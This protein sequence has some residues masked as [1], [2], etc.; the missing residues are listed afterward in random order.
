MIKTVKEKAARIGRQ[1]IRCVITVRVS[2]LVF[3]NDGVLE[4]GSILTLCFEKSGR[5]ATSNQILFD[6]SFDD[7]NP[8]VS[9]KHLKYTT[10]QVD[11]KLELAVSLYK[12]SD[13]NEYQAKRGKITIRQLQRNTTLGVDA[14]KVIGSHILLLHEAV[15]RLSSTPSSCIEDTLSMD[16]LPGSS[17]QVNISMKITHKKRGSFQLRKSIATLSKGAL[18][19]WGNN[20]HTGR[21]DTAGLGDED[22]TGSN[23]SD[24]SDSSVFST[25]GATFYYEDLEE[26]GGGREI[27]VTTLGGTASPQRLRQ[28]Q[29]AQEQ[30]EISDY[31]AVYSD[32]N[33][34]SRLQG[35]LPSRR[36]SGLHVMEVAMN[37]A[38]NEHILPLPKPA[39]KRPSLPN[40]TSAQLPSTQ[41]GTASSESLLVH[42][43]DPEGE[44][45]H[46]GTSSTEHLLEASIPPSLTIPVAHTTHNA[47][48]TATV[49]LVEAPANENSSSKSPSARHLCRTPTAAVA[50][51]GQRHRESIGSRA[52]IG[53]DWSP[54]LAG[55]LDHVSGG[56]SERLAL[57]AGKGGSRSSLSSP[58]S[59]ASMFISYY[60]YYIYI[61]I[62]DRI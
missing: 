42:S 4:P 28:H 11:E 22:E 39:P 10:I 21:K 53:N 19:G 16:G 15:E 8:I 14:F 32:T 6:P 52:S 46:T 47:T 59:F 38:S 13:T 35:K 2:Q 27:T 3:S 51:P 25:L 41:H 7:V 1:K 12:N 50:I 34:F 18:S 29:Q 57:S 54:L 9:Q 40:H 17:L 48:D 49:V 20:P 24:N 31:E 37:E 43:Q 36:S 58:V 55:S 30:S 23:A 44:C 26:Y 61:Y 33:S 60:Y 5:I 45:E 56:L 62:L